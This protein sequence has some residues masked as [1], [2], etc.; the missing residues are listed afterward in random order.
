MSKKSTMK[1]ILGFNKG[2]RSLED[3]NKE[4]AEIMQKVA[5][6][7][8]LSYVYEKETEGLNKRALELNRE[9]AERNKLETEKK[10]KEQLKSATQAAKEEVANVQS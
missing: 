10:Q 1:N 6:S 5:Q 7:Q 4:Y 3:I 9:A 8:Y 2:P